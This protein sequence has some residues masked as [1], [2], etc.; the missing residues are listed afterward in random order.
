M[1]AKSVKLVDRIKRSRAKPSIDETY[2]AALIED[3]QRMGGDK[4]L[5]EIRNQLKPSRESSGRAVHPLTEMFLQAQARTYFRDR[6][7]FINAVIE[8]AVE[9]RGSK[10]ELR[11]KDRSLPRLLTEY[12][13][14]MPQDELEALINRVAAKYAHS[15]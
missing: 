9:A 7:S 1:Q 4:V 5:E 3:V 8:F 2:F 15:R 13:R 14:L 12:S 10:L 11:K 6:A